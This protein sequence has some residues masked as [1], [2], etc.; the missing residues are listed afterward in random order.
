MVAL[1]L[2]C[3]VSH[4]ID[5]LVNDYGGMGLSHDFVYL[6]ALGAN[7]KGDHAFWDE[8]YDGERFPPYFLKDLIDVTE[9]TSATLVLTVHFSI[10]DLG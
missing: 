9:E 3:P 7:K 10:V 8:Y 5:G 4:S 6:V 1:N 2:D